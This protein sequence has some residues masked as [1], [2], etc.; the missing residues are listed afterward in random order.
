MA[1]REFHRVS[2]TMLQPKDFL[3]R[4][5]LNILKKNLNTLQLSQIFF[6]CSQSDLGILESK[7]KFLSSNYESLTFSNRMNFVFGVKDRHDGKMNSHKWF[8]DCI[9]SLLE[10]DVF[11]F[12]D[13]GT[14]PSGDSILNMYKYM[15]SK[16]KCGGCCGE[17]EVDMY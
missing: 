8:F 9:C 17:I 13:I 7:I 14:K 15:Q 16:P 4:K 6:M 3:I 1:T 2:K 5:M 12:L 11:L 10:P